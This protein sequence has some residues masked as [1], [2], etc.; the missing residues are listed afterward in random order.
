MRKRQKG[1]SIKG[2]VGEKKGKRVLKRGAGVLLAVLSGMANV[3]F[4]GGGGLLIV[5]ALSR[6]MEV[7]ERKAHAGAIAVMLPLSV[8]SALIYTMR[9]VYDLSLVWSVGGGALLGGALGA[10][11]L[12]KV[13]KGALELIFCGVMI[14]AGVK[15]L[16]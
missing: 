5:P 16:K 3:L 12:R 11:L 1:N 15:L 7:E 8:I 2:M 4:G 6:C 9:G 14:F 13:P 10:G